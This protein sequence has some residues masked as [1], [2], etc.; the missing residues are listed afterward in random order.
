M[1]VS[2]NLSAP[3]V[4]ANYDV[5]TSSVSKESQNILSKFITKSLNGYAAFYFFN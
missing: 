4:E 3:F 2:V 1:N 5:P